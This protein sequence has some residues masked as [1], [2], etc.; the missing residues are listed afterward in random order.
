MVALA[1]F[2]FLLTRSESEFAAYGGV[3]VFA[4]ILWLWLID[5]V[6]PTSWDLIGSCVAIA[7]MAIIMFAPR[8]P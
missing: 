8:S 4:A 1:L 5:G 2:A 6:R 3:Y 7:G